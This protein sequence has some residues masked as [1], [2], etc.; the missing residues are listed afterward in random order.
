MA[1]RRTVA[2]RARDLA[3][4]TKPSIVV[5]A[6]LT[7]AG[8]AALGGGPLPSLRLAVILAGTALLVAAAAALNQLLERDTDARMRRTADR[9]LPAGR[10][11]PRFVLALGLVLGAAGAAALGVLANPTTA[12]VGVFALAV[13][14]LGY[15]P[16]K[17]VSSL[18]L[19]VG[20]VPGACPALMGYAGRTGRIG[21]PGLVLFAVLFLWQLPHFIA[22]ATYLKEDYARGG[23]RVVSLTQGDRAARLEAV[24]AAAALWLVS[25]LLVPLGG[26]GRVY[27][28]GALALGLAFTA[29]GV[30][31]LRRRADAR[32]A[33]RYFLCSLAYLPAYAA[34]L[35]LDLAMR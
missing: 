20:A 32:W 34:V 13:Y 24:V 8:G 14:V 11:T 10:V 9:P 31:G 1:P 17:R 15:T 3:T 26:A 12:A 25:L 7:A 30:V 23:L 35:A 27:L 28:V 6:M 16:L 2:A 18:A 4:L 21:V 22:I 29:Y 5:M 33:R 19:V